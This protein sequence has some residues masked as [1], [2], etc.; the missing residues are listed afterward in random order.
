VSDEIYQ[1]ALADRDQ[2]RSRLA[3]LEQRLEADLMTQTEEPIADRRRRLR[4]A[5]SWRED[6]EMEGL[7]RQIDRDPAMQIS[8]LLRMQI[9]YYQEGKKAASDQQARENRR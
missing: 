9:G 7:L 4:A 6:A 3:E 8:S 1:R 5:A 2:I